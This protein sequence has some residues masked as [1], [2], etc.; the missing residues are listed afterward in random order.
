MEMYYR[1]LFVRYTG[2]ATIILFLFCFLTGCKNH[3]TQEENCIYP[4]GELFFDTREIFWGD[5]YWGEERWDTI[6]IFNPTEKPVRLNTFGQYPDVIYRTKRQNKWPIAGIEIPA[7]TYDTLFI[8]LKITDENR[9]GH[10]STML[11]FNVNNQVNYTQGIFLDAHIVENFDGMEETEKEAAPEVSLSV[12]EIDFG[13]MPQGKEL[14]KS[15]EIINTGKRDL[16]IRKIETSCGCTAVTPDKRLIPPNG[17]V[18]LDIL[19]NTTGRSG[20]QHKTVTL[21]CNDPVSP[22][23]KL[24]LK[25]EVI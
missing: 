21:I 7:G 19:F 15:M 9:Y 11:H 10:F 12:R 13:S 2:V 20:K 24:I 14:R 23:I 5:T 3:E 1:N 8:G 25:G 4:V 18:T 16:I 17:K 22:E 6:R